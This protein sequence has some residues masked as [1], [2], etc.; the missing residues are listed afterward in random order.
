[1]IRNDMRK[2]FF[3][4]LFP[5]LLDLGLE[6]SFQ[7]SLSQQGYLLLMKRLCSKMPSLSLAQ[8]VGRPNVN[9]LIG[10]RL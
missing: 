9:P 8:I 2:A 1:M 3:H 5:P 7:T 10:D 6:S 4:L